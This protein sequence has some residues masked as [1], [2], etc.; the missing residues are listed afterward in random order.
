MNP[1][2]CELG[3]SELLNFVER[4]GDTSRSQVCLFGKKNKTEKREPELLLVKGHLSV[5]R[6][7]QD[8][9]GHGNKLVSQQ[10]ND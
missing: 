4:V 10:I 1:E 2:F 9:L 6:P 8:L 5:L 3:E 7:D